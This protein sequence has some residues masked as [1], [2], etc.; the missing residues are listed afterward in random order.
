MGEEG[1]AQGDG[2]D[3]DALRRLTQCDALLQVT[4]LGIHLSFFLVKR[5]PFAV[6]GPCSDWSQ[7]LKRGGLRRAARHLR[8]F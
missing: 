6:C 2:C 5:A 8:L 4:S 3:D 7:R 1:V